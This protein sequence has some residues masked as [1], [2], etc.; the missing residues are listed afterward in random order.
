MCGE[1]NYNMRR[2]LISLFLIQSFVFSAQWIKDINN[3]YR[4]AVVRVHNY[5]N[6]THVSCGTGF[7]VGADGL[8]VTN[9]HVIEGADRIT[10]IDINNEELEVSGYYFLNKSKDYAIIKVPGFQMPTVLLGNSKITEVGDDVIAI[11]HP[12]GLDYTVTDG[13]ISQIVQTKGTKLIQI[14]VPIDHGS[15]GGPLF[16]KNGKVIG[17]TTSGFEGNFNFAIPIHYIQGEL[18]TKPYTLKSFKNLVPSEYQHKKA[19]VINTKTIPYIG[20]IYIQTGFLLG[21]I[22]QASYHFDSVNDAYINWAKLYKVVKKDDGTRFPK[23]KYFSNIRFEKNIFYGT[24]DWRE[25]GSTALGASLW[26]YEMH[27]SD[28]Y[29]RIERGTLKLANSRGQIIDT[30]YFDSDLKYK[31]YK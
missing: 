29:G 28:D 9:Y 3:N 23:R 7:I 18:N 15:S 22:G 4:K 31:L 8:I 25:E 21:K 27:F 12:L 13:I 14:S 2:L 26:I 11:G 10:I 24:I 6:N 5:Q 30:R 17:I 1:L 20:N 19:E 16:N